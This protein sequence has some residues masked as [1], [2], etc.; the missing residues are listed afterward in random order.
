[1]SDGDWSQADD[2]EWYGTDAHGWGFW[3]T[4]DTMDNWPPYAALRTRVAELTKAI[5]A[6]R[7][8]LTEYSEPSQADELLYA[9]LDPDE[10][11]G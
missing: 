7:R 1:V 2:G 6:H 11:D 4:E 8:W 3:F 9:T 10:T 5:E